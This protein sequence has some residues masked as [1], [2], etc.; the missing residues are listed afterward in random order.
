MAPRERAMSR[1]QKYSLICTILALA[2][3]FTLNYGNVTYGL[4][5]CLPWSIAYGLAGLFSIKK[6]RIMLQRPKGPGDPFE[7]IDLAFIPAAAASFVVVVNLII[8]LQRPDPAGSLLSWKL[9]ALGCFFVAQMVVA[10]ASNTMGSTADWE[11]YYKKPEEPLLMQG[12]DGQEK[13]LSDAEIAK[14]QGKTLRRAALSIV[15]AIASLALTGGATV[16]IGLLL[17]F[18]AL[19]FYASASVSALA[20]GLTI[21]VPSWSG[22]SGG[23]ARLSRVALFVA[24]LLS[25][26]A[27]A[28]VLMALVNGKCI[29]R[30]VRWPFLCQCCLSRRNLV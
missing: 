24:Q 20:L 6:K 30:S 11:N 4:L 21:G 28:S 1:A 2:T 10:F 5:L 13:L 12:D 17:G 7:N 18:A 19:Y 23:T 22:L 27:S 25:F 3:L 15:A 14:S 8:L 9:A 26:Y 29:Y 16:I